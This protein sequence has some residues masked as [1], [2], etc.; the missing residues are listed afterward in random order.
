MR[1]INEYI[2]SHNIRRFMANMGLP[3]MITN[4]N[5]GQGPGTTRQNKKVQAIDGIWASHSIKPSQW[6]YLT[7]YDGPKSDRRLLWINISHGIAFGE[8]RTPYMA[9]E[10]R[11]IRLDHIRDQKKYKSNIILLTREKN[12]LQRLRDFKD[13]HPPQKKIQRRI[14]KHKPFPD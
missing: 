12:L 1:D 4:K 6:G 5:G 9:P 11:R 7:F 2:L 14:R 10:A 3:E 13:L 8:N